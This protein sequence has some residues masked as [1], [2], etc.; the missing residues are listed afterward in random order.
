M[1][2]GGRDLGKGEITRS[3]SCWL[4][5]TAP[6]LAF[7]C[8]T[9]VGPIIPRHQIWKVWHL[10]R[11]GQSYGHCAFAPFDWLTRRC[12]PIKWYRCGPSLFQH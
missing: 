7:T 11:Y 4:L 6:G 5:R 3:G 10:M 12:L 2:S 1:S 8:L 9:Q